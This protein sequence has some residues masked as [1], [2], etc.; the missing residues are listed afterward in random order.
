MMKIDIKGPIVSDGN[1]W[2]YDWYGAPA[3]APKD[4]ISC[5]KE[6]NGEDVSLEIASNGGLVTSAIEIYQALK[7]Y[8][9]KITA[10][11]AYACSAATVISCAADESEI[12]E[13]GF[14]MIHNSQSYAEGDKNEMDHERGVLSALDEGIIT[15]YE[16]KTG[17]TR[18]DIQALM[19][20]STYMSA[21]DAVENGFV[22]RLAHAQAEGENIVQKAVASAGCI[23]PNEKIEV[24]ASMIR[25]LTGEDAKQLEGIEDAIATNLQISGWNA[26]SDNKPRKGEKNMKLE[27]IMAENPEISNEIE[28]RTVAARAEGV[29]EGIRQE[30]ERMRSLDSIANRVTA[31]QLNEAKYGE[32]PVDAPT[33]AFKAMQEEAAR[34][35]GYIR[36]AVADAEDSGVNEIGVGEIH[37]GEEDENAK[38]AD[39]MASHVNQRKDGK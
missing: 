35:A 32:E 5:L 10:R 38:L 33:L 27:E 34:S 14:F 28:E 22:D 19:D 26:G 13:I 24:M 7:D 18:E 23:I 12:L 20:N 36:D 25:M 11:I 9:G 29:E 1:K 30:R 21:A 16:K 17:A 39:E 3:T 2:I 31:K 6:A 37:A 15:A 8:D 4:V